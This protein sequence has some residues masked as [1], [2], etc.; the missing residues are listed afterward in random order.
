M[1]FA[2][3]LSTVGASHCLFI[4]RRD[5][6]SSANGP[7][8]LESRPPQTASP[9]V[10][11]SEYIYIRQQDT[12][13]DIIVTQTKKRCM[14]LKITWIMSP[15]YIFRRTRSAGGK[16]EPQG[17]LSCLKRSHGILVLFFFSPYHPFSILREQSVSCYEIMGIHIHSQF[18]SVRANTQRVV[19]DKR[20][21]M[22]DISNPV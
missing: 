1:H 14:A 8:R 19:A 10:V 15:C 3:I 13:L 20:I 11:G 2:L 6:Q 5:R 12:V 17:Q 4:G 9:G 22:V 21:R 18:F 16:M 7:T